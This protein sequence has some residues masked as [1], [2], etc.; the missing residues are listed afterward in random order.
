MLCGVCDRLDLIRDS[1]V[2]NWRGRFSELDKWF[3]TNRPYI[4]WDRKR[5]CILVDQEAKDFGSPTERKLRKI[6]ELK[7]PWPLPM[8]EPE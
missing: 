1:S 6:P 7:P 5:S 3:Q 2:K 8:P 4:R